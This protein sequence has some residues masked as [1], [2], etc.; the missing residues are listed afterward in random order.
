MKKI[1]FT[2]IFFI[3]VSLSLIIMGLILPET[4][5]KAAIIGGVIVGALI[6]FDIQAANIAK[7]SEDNPKVK[8]LRNLS[9]MN[10][11]IVIIISIYL[12]LSPF[13]TGFSDK[14]N[15]ILLVG[16]V[17]I[18]MMI[19]G[20]AAPKIPFN[21]YLGLRLPWTI[22]DEDTWKVAHKIIGYLSF[23]AAII[24]FVLTFFYSAQTATSICVLGWII[25]PSLYSLWFYNKKYHIV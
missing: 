13:I 22:R 4:N 18:V 2:R 25:I 5:I 8:T 10:I 3:L 20:N 19:F 11:F 6:V 14:T 1:D 24:Q 12:T 17:S 21:R 16:A 15:E 9:R 7:L 23:P